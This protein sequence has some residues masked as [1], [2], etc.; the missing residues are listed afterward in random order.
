[1]N[2]GEYQLKENVSL[3]AD[4]AG[5]FCSEALLTALK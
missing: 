1:M 3:P 2:Y 4:E 5:I